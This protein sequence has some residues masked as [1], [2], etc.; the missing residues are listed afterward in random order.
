[1]VT[2]PETLITAYGGEYL[3]ARS[4]DDLQAGDLIECLT[5]ADCG[6]GSTTHDHY[7]LG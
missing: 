4:V 2:N 6:A 3:V 1:M 7:S 5:L